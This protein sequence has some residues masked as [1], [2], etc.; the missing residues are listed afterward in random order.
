MARLS[1]PERL[2][3]SIGLSLVLAF[4][5]P[6]VPAS[7]GQSAKSPG[8]GGA[9]FS[10]I[11][12]SPFGTALKSPPAQ[13]TR[14][15]PRVSLFQLVSL[16]YGVTEARASGGE[17]WMFDPLDRTWSIS[18]KA[19]G[20]VS[21]ATFLEMLRNM[22]SDRFGLRVERRIE[23]T[24]TVVLSFPSKDHPPGLRKASA[25]VDC[26][27]FLTGL[28][29]PL[30]APRAGGVP[31]CGPGSVE[32]FQTRPVF[33]YRSAPLREF[34]RQLELLLDRPVN[35]SPDTDR[36]LDIDF[37]SPAGYEYNAKDPDIDAFLTALEDQL[38][39]TGEVHRGEVEMLHILVAHAPVPDH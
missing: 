21:Y 29:S 18:V 3:V 7:A 14:F 2:A 10:A 4:A 13:P 12:I 30:D 38:G 6:A 25:A 20:P 34:G 26:T 5:R 37:T 15:F 35:V 16:A 19:D 32:H 27:P 9:R 24:S 17:P 22:L 31:L 33:H 8:A 23:N 28:L 36:L 11:A 1:L 39:A